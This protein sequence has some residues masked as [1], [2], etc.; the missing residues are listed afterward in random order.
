MKLAKLRGLHNKITNWFSGLEVEKEE[1]STNKASGRVLGRDVFVPEDLPP[2]TRSAV[3]GY[4]V[5]A[6]DTFGAGESHPAYF[7]VK[8]EVKMGEEPDFV[9]QQGEAAEIATGAMLPEGADS[10]IMVEHTEMIA[11]SKLEVYRDI[12]V[13]ENVINRGDD[14]HKG[15]KLLSRG[16]IISP[17]DIGALSGLG[18]VKIEVYAKP[19]ASILAT[20]DEV[21]PPEAEKKR[22]QIRDIN[23]PALSSLFSSWGFNIRSDSIIP[24]REE[25]LQNT[26]GEHLDSDLI[27]ISGGSSVGQR[28]FTLKVIDKLGEPG[29]LLHGLAVKPGKPTI[30]GLVKST[31]V[32]GL[33]GNPASAWI[34]SCLLVPVLLDILQNREP[35]KSLAGRPEG[36]SRRLSR[37]IN[38]ARGRDEFIP[39]KLED[40]D[41]AVPI[42]GKSNLITT[43]VEA[44]GLI[45]I[46]AKS[47]GL[48]KDE[49]VEVFSL[50]S[51][52]GLPGIRGDNEDDRR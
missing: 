42:P 2:F 17:Q 34:V 14:V 51:R 3:D 22:G 49:I 1:V 52:R 47:E 45:H 32:I 40:G 21:I 31:P 26:I 20:G 30:L 25:A 44:E 50:S 48:D 4:A 15:D 35:M 5:K 33:P 19:T 10:C 37:R 16:R 13:G 39:V 46:P 7:N 41:E 23:T 18:I 24:D 12:A 38:S 11:G 27:V 36:I 28:D 9:L 6:E 29:V 8:Y 43:L